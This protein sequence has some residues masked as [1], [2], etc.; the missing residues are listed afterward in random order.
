M[1]QGIEEANII[2]WQSNLAVYEAGQTNTVIAEEKGTF[3]EIIKANVVELFSEGFARRVNKAL[4]HGSRPGEYS[5]IIEGIITDKNR[6][7]W[8]IEDYP[9]L[10]KD[11]LAG[12][13]FRFRIEKL[14]SDPIYSFGGYSFSKEGVPKHLKYIMDQILIEASKL[15]PIIKRA[16]EEKPLTEQMEILYKFRNTLKENL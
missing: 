5:A 15:F 3:D 16:L 2:T 7:R 14:D 10:V 11:N 12:Y 4:E 1:D 8:N 13:R 9:P 6:V